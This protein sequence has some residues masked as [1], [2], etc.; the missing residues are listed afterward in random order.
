MSTTPGARSR[1]WSATR[2]RMPDHRGAGRHR[3]RPLWPRPPTRLMSPLLA[4]ALFAQVAAPAIPEPRVI[5][6]VEVVRCAGLTQAA[7]ELE[8]GESPEGRS[9][10]DAALYWS[11]AASQAALAS[12]RSTVDADADQT[13]ARILAVRQLESAS[14]GAQGDLAACRRRTP[15]L[16]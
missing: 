9:L 11:L 8:G 13:R 1:T 10:F 3:A 6:Y 4:L 5:P 14:T 2:I 16:G 15:D 12:G 7:S